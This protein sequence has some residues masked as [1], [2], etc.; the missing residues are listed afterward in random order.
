MKRTE[1]KVWMF[2]CL[3]LYLEDLKRENPLKFVLLSRYLRNNHTTLNILFN[4]VIN[5]HEEHQLNTQANVLRD[6][7]NYFR[8]RFL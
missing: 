8:N 1:K 7:A 4:R 5:N 6:A 3:V 2:I